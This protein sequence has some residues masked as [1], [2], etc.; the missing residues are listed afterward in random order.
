MS[1]FVFLFIREQMCISV[2]LK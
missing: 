1:R 2:L